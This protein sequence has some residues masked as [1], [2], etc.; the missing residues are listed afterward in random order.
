MD[1]TRK[2]PYCAEEIRAEALRCPHCRS[3]IAALD[4][5]RWYRDHPERRLAGVAAAV[6]HALALPVIWVR[7]GFIALT[8]LHFLGPIAYVALLALI[9]FTPGGTS[10]LEQGIATVQG[11]LG[12]GGRGAPPPRRPANG[13][14]ATHFDIVSGGP[15]A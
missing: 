8:F 5:T 13:A 4:P 15:L 7:V 1:E 12:S 14:D 9:P 6:A 3:R 11:W 2:C 10:L